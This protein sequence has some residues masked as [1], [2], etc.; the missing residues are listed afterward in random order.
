MYGNSQ[1]QVKKKIW[2][3]SKVEASGQAEAASAGTLCKYVLHSDN[4]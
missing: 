3:L 2:F 1:L 4:Q